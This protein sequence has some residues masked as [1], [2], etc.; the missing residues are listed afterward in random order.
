M[1][2]PHSLQQDIE[3]RIRQSG[4]ESVG[5]A[6]R[7]LETGQDL[8]ADAN[9]PFHPASTFKICVMMELYRQAR[10]GG[11]PLD[12]RL[13]IKN[14]FHSIV[15]GSSFSLAPEDDAETSLYARIGET[16]TLRELCRL[17]IV[18]SG[19]LA[20]NLLIEALGAGNVTDFMHALGAP[21]LQVVRGTYDTLAVEQGRNNVATARGLDH[22][23]TRLAEGSVVSADASREMVEI[24]L[25]QQFNEGIPAGILPTLDGA[26]VAHKTGW[27]D[28]HYHDAAIIFPPGR[29]PLRPRRADARPG[30]IDRCPATGGVHRPGGRRIADS[31]L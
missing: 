14:A 7:D 31:G 5:V 10:S 21:S 15:D 13:P 4:A 19:N 27:I 28:R 17:M 12:S 20:T 30:R 2:T 16:E 29:A 1:N 25:A 6:F 18:R 9:E 22:I 23:L 3:E 24:L 26:K 11:L 8:F